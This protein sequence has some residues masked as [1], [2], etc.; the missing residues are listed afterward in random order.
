VWADGELL[1]WLW[2]DPAVVSLATGTGISGVAGSSTDWLRGPMRT[3]AARAAAAV[4]ADAA[5]AWRLRRSGHKHASDAAG[6][7]GIHSAPHAAGFRVAGRALGGLLLLLLGWLLLRLLLGLAQSAHRLQ[8]RLAG[9]GGAAG[10]ARRHAAR[11]AE[12]RAEGWDGDAVSAV[13]PGDSQGRRRLAH[14]RRG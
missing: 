6:D 12:R 4:I 13:A 9:G 5:E 2:G 1:G 7:L 8:L 10:A 14:C 11:W 3:T